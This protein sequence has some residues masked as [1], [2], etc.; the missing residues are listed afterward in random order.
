MKN[1]MKNFIK[2]ILLAFVLLSIGFALGK[3]FNYRNLVKGKKIL[4]ANAKK[5]ENNAV[6]HVYYMHSI[7]RCSTCNTIEKMTK[8]LL[9]SK[10][11][12][13][14]KQGKIIFLDVDFQSNEHLTKRFGIVSSCVVVAI[15]KDKKILKFKRLDKVWTLMKNPLEFNTYIS[16][17]VQTYLDF[18]NNINSTEE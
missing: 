14:I 18:E 9:D 13:Q 12:N 3:H 2:K 1:T 10:Y 5:V 15:V 8:E 7:F 11:I 4:L 6:V 16:K 17:T